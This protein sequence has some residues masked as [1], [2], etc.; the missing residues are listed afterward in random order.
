MKPRRPI[1]AWHET[2][3]RG[4]QVIEYAL[5]LP[6]GGRARVWHGRA[7]KKW[8]ISVGDSWRIKGR[9][10]ATVAAAKR[11]AEDELRL[12]ISRAIALLNGKTA[13]RP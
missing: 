8:H 2:G 13:I 6:D 9:D 5:D 11:A 4:R 10:F 1:K 3:W 7:S 12:R